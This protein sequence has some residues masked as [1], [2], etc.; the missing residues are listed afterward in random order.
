MLKRLFLGKPVHWIAL[1][2]ALGLLWWVG[3]Q[4]MHVRHFNQFTGIL[5]AATLALVA[6]V[7]VT[8]KKGEKVTRDDIPPPSD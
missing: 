4:R 5:A 7:L 8:T 6:I 2:A 3:E 1:L